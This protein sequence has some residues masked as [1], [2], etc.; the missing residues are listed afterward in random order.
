MQIYKTKR[1]CNKA[2][3]RANLCQSCSAKQRTVRE[4]K[5]PHIGVIPTRVC[6]GCHAELVYSTWGAFCNCEAKNTQCVKCSALARPCVRVMEETVVKLYNAGVSDKNISKKIGK[7][8]STVKRVLHK[9][10][11]STS[12]AFDAKRLQPKID[13]YLSLNGNLYR[14][15]NRHCTMIKNRAKH[16]VLAFNLTTDYL[17]MLFQRQNGL[18]FYSDQPIS[19]EV[20]KGSRW[21]QLSL[22]RIKPELGYT[23]GNVVWCTR[24]INTIK[25]DVTLGEMKDWMPGWY[26]RIIQ[27]ASASDEVKK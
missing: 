20:G 24:R 9:H 11:L 26:Q 1:G 17:L 14:R 16:A 3:K 10:G 18:C 19:V 5:T 15:L 21:E 13:N 27:H 7:H 4:G 22:D 6:S 2:I 12:R 8:I 25:N 23:Q